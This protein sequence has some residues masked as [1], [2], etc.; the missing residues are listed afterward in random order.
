MSKFT[1]SIRN[2]FRKKFSYSIVNEIVLNAIGIFVLKVSQVFLSILLA[3]VLGRKVGPSGLGAYSFAISTVGIAIIIAVVG[4]PQIVI[5]ETAIYV[6][7]KKWNLLKGL[8]NWSQVLVLIISIVLSVFIFIIIIIFGK[9]DNI[10]HTALLICL[11]SLPP[12]A[13]LRIRQSFLQGLNRMILGLLP[14]TLLQPSITIIFVI[15]LS[16]LYQERL[17]P[18]KSIWAHNF[19]VTICYIIVF[20]ILYYLIPRPV[21]KCNA[22]CNINDWIHSS[23]PLLFV[24]SMHVLNN[25]LDIV[26]IGFF[27]NADA[28]G[29]YTAAN[30]ATQFIAFG[31]IATSFALRP[32]VANAH[33]NGDREFIQKSLTSSARVGLLIAIPII[34]SFVIFGKY[35][36]LLFGHGFEKGYRCLMILSIAQLVNNGAGCVAMILTSC[37]YERQTAFGILMG[38]ISNIIL[39]FLLIPIW[40]IEGA[41]VAS[42]VSMI[43]WNIVLFKIVRS[44]LGMTPGPIRRT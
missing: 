30:R 43:V 42:G 24:Q 38:A 10:L 15:I 14:E 11:I 22:V 20:A 6:S 28:V 9:R 7:Q 40:G 8:L 33:A 26:M 5:R 3:L 29:V 1:K 41:A 23:I 21:H 35:I 19:A 34:I 37:R 25:R 12:I 4:L 27:L 18:L 39:N 44:R 16:I 31:L 17:T 13:Q 36:L 32:K 2:F